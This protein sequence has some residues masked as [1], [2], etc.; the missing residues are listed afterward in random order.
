MKKIILIAL[1]LLYILDSNLSFR[2]SYYRLELE[3][4][5]LAEGKFKIAHISDLHNRNITRDLSDR[6]K[7]ENPDIIA[8]TGDLI[9]SNRTDIPQALDFID[10]VKDKYPVY[11][12][13]GN[14][15]GRSPHY[16]ELKEALEKRNVVV[17]TDSWDTID[18]P[19]GKLSIC[20][21]TDPEFFRF[22]N[23]KKTTVGHRL[24]RIRPSEHFKVLLAH[25]PD[26]FSFYDDRGFDLV[27]SGHA[28]GGQV[29]LPLIGGLFAPN[30]GVFPKYSKGLY[31]G[32][33]SKMIVSRGLGNSVFPLRIGN[34]PEL[35]MVNICNSH[36]K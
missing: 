35:V 36:E 11:Y 18:S 7:E 15:E 9:D 28:H 22:S 19:L 3:S 1:L 20:G 12:V 6:V 16:L 24:D 5:K 13:P 2:T 8:I 4:L 14:H 25:R 30:Q 21:F 33:T 32:R 27:L 31:E 23:S 10:R 26:L 29:R 34:K 17:L